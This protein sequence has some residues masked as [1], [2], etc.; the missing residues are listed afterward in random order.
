M[1]HCI[2]HSTIVLDYKGNFFLYH[3]QNELESGVRINYWRKHKCMNELQQ[4]TLQVSYTDHINEEDKE[5]FDFP[6]TN[7]SS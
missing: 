1:V 2:P 5:V 6:H 7:S 3:L 4:T